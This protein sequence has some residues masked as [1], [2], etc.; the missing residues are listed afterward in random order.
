MCVF[1]GTDHEKRGLVVED[2]GDSPG[3]AVDVGTS[4]I[5]D[6]ARR[7]AVRLDDGDLVFVDSDDLASE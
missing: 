2:F 1:P 7:W 6:P 3:Y 4:H 5:A